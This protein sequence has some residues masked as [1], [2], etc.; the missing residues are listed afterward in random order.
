MNI[1]DFRDFRK[2]WFA[3]QESFSKNKI[4]NSQVETNNKDGLEIEN[5]QFTEDEVVDWNEPVAPDRAEILNAILDEML[6]AFEKSK[7]FSDG[8]DAMD[9]FIAREG[10]HLTP[11]E[12]NKIFRAY[13]MVTSGAYT[14]EELPPPFGSEVVENLTEA[15]RRNMKEKKKIQKNSRYKENKYAKKVEKTMC[16]SDIEDIDEDDEF[17]KL[18]NLIL[19]SQYTEEDDI[20]NK[21]VNAAKFKE[22]VTTTDV[23]S[24]IGRVP[25]SKIRKETQKR[26]IKEAEEFDDP[27]IDTEDSDDD[28]KDQEEDSGSTIENLLDQLKDKFQEKFPGK[29][30][31]ITVKSSDEPIDDEIVSRAKDVT[32][33]TTEDD[34]EIE[35]VEDDES[36]EKNNESIDDIEGKVFSKGQETSLDDEENIKNESYRKTIR[37]L[38]KIILEAEKELNDIKKEFSDEKDDQEDSIEDNVENV[39]NE[40]ET[41]TIPDEETDTT[42]NK[43][44]DNTEEVSQNQITLS[45]DNWK[46]VLD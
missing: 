32:N 26:R 1:Y 22:T 8:P 10:I 27:K 20:I 44:S 29:E 4:T 25:D 9:K 2:K 40:K 6:N 28:T 15:R 35:K 41:D 23:G 33:N 46:K 7:K 18:D 12:E 43:E 37:T 24:G 36:D 30:I 3:L 19:N 38:R 14:K 11:K 31:L 16:D 34:E 5:Q 42:S 45:I 17:D 21:I 39:E 13:R